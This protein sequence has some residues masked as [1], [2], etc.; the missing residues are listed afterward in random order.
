M[1]GL[2][3]R[4]RRGVDGR[5]GPGL[6]VPPACTTGAEVTTGVHWLRGTTSLGRD[7][8]LA[9]LA[10]RLGESVVVLERGAYGYSEGYGV[11]GVRVLASESRPDMGVCVDVTGTG[12][13]EL[14]L[15]RLAELRSALELRVSRLDVAVDGC[16]FTPVDLRD[17]WR[18][19]Q[20]RTR[21]KVPDDAREDRQWRTSAWR[22]DPA[23]DLFTMG[24]RSSSQYARCYDSRGFTRLE[25]ELKDRTAELAAVQ[26]LDGDLDGFASEALGWVR[27]FVDFVDPDSDSNPSRRSLLP[28]WESFC[29]MVPR[30]RVALD[31]VIVRTVAQVRGWVERQVAPALALVAEALGQEELRRLLRVG[32]DR[33]R[34][35][36]RAMLR[37]AAVPA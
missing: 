10:S 36:H 27:R 1:T 33:W 13:E 22:S 31:G 3:G 7:A 23:G 32:K 9:W 24:A 29:G 5:S 12:C 34:P 6:P 16:P 17:A 21:A 25:L 14:G 35:R 30:A 8:V 28:F 11:G 19:G 26:L 4:P 18:S 37:A 2:S 20:V 15:R